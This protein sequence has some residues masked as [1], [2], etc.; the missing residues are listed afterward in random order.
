LYRRVIALDGATGEG[1][2]C[3]NVND[4]IVCV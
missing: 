2:F 1:Y 3:L 4:T